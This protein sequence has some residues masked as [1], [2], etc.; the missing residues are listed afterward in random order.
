MFYVWSAQVE[1]TLLCISFVHIGVIDS[2]GMRIW[3]ASSPREHDAGMLAVGYSVNPHMVIPPNA[4]NFTITS[5]VHEE[6]TN[7]VCLINISWR[8]CPT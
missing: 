1:S 2:S 4:K 3:Y 8:S 7:K 5:F 6:C